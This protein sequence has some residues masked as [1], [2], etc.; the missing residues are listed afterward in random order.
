M[1][2]MKGEQHDVCRLASK[3]VSKTTGI[4]RTYLF[5][6]VLTKD[7][8]EYGRYMEVQ[9]GTDR[10]PNKQQNYFGLK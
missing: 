5:L 3:E 6:L 2:T 9:D 4:W 1:L 7:T 8:L 10:R